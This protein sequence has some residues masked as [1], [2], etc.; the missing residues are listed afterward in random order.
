[1]KDFSGRLFFLYPDSQKKAELGRGQT[2]FE[3]DIVF[4]QSDLA[5]SSVLDPPLAN[6]PFVEIKAY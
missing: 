1:M 4:C 6:Q 5:G 3:G 2:I